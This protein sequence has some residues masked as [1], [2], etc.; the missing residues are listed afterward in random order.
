MPKKKLNHISIKKKLFLAPQLNDDCDLQSLK[1]MGKC[2]GR[3]DEQPSH[4]Q[5]DSNSKNCVICAHFGD[6]NKLEYFPPEIKIHILKKE[7]SH[8]IQY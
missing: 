3:K 6:C 8:K 1:S 7:N 5:A 2:V 4:S